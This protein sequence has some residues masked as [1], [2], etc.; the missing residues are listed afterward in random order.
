MPPFVPMPNACLRCPFELAALRSRLLECVTTRC[1]PLTCSR[2]TRAAENHA[3]MIRSRQRVCCQPKRAPA[4]I[5][6]RGTGVLYLTAQ[7]GF[8][9][10]PMHTSLRAGVRRP[11]SGGRCRRTWFKLEHDDEGDGLEL[12]HHDGYELAAAAKVN[13]V[14]GREAPADVVDLAAYRR[15][16]DPSSSE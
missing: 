9:W 1:A 12:A 15:R 3:A 4:D 7:L 5:R 2:P 8:V 11:T 10:L 13:A 14:H 6:A 16:I